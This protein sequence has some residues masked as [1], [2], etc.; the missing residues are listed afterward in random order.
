MIRAISLKE[1]I[2]EGGK[3][4]QTIQNID[5]N[6]LLNSATSINSKSSGF[7]YQYEILTKIPNFQIFRKKRICNNILI[8]DIIIL[9]FYY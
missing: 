7:V 8:I 3:T 1:G 9:L 6:T 5:K 4:G 2:K